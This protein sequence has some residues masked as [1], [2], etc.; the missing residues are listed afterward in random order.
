MKKNVELIQHRISQL[1]HERIITSSRYMFYQA[2]TFTGAAMLLA[3][4]LFYLQDDNKSMLFFSYAV[5][6]V[7]LLGFCTYSLYAHMHD[8]EI[9]ERIKK[10][11]ELL[12]EGKK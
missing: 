11:Y 1:K 3:A 4:I 2:F 9:N 8:K 12:L 6:L 5:L 7:A 10:N